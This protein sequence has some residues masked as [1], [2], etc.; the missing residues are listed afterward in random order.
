MGVVTIVTHTSTQKG[1]RDE[2]YSIME[3]AIVPDLHFDTSHRM[4]LPYHTSIGER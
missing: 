2:Y 3:F 1:Q 4:Q